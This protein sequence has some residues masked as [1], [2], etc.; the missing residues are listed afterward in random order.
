M[1]IEVNKGLKVTSLKNKKAISTVVSTL[2]I[3]GTVFALFAIIYPWFTSSLT[4]SQSSA[5][6]WYLSQEEASKERIVIE[7]VVFEVDAAGNKY[8][9]IFVRNVGEIDVKISAIY[10]NGSAQTSVDPSLPYRLYVSANGAVNVQ[11]F[12][13][14][15]LWSENEIYMI[16]VVT[17]RGAEAI[18]E[19][20]R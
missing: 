11:N 2:I 3:I 13:I 1:I 7:M 17:S 18:Y 15:Y 8:V 5:G 6:L 12:K 4:F 9:N 20:K 10:I 14:A 19:A 16:K